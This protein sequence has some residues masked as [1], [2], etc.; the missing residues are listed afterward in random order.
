MTDEV[1]AQ[2]APQ[3]RPVWRT[4]LRA[5]LQYG[6]SALVFY[7]LFRFLPAHQV[8]ATLKRLSAQLWLLAIAGY[9]AAHLI[10]AVK[11]RLVLNMGGAGLSPRNAA[12]CYFAGL[13][14]SLFLPSLIGGDILRIAMALRVGRSKAAVF[15][16]S[17]VDRLSD[18]TALVLLAAVGA[19]LVPGGL[20]EKDRKIFLLVIAAAAVAGVIAL[21]LIALFPVRK[22]SIK[23]R[24][25]LVRLREAGREIL[26]QPGTMLRA[27]SM[28][29]LVQLAFITLNVMLA[30]ACGLD[31]PFRVWL[32]AWPLA[33]L[34]AAVPITQAGIGVREAATA[35]LLLPF[36]AAPQLSVATGLAWDAVV[37]G[38]AIAGGVFALIVG[39]KPE[40][41]Q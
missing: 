41:A 28:S 32:F 21:G 27:L 11:Y 40:Q 3:P 26:R 23:I 13:F 36:G 24:R 37:V 38:G 9:L 31:L 35:A 25:K 12:R 1:N 18:F 5:A 29:V 20:S 8:L 7:I 34:S 14:G 15:L 10:G 30:V 19:V 22:L 17:F 33:K 2:F 6:A 16:G 39:S 4:V